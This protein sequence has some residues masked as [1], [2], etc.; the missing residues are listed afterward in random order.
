MQFDK[1]IDCNQCL[2]LL[3]SFPVAISSINLGLL[4]VGA[5]WKTGFELIEVLA[6]L[7]KV[8]VI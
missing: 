7:G 2:S 6:T 8:G 5:K 1:A 4:R 3:L